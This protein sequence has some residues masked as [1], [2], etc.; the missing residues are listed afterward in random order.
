MSLLKVLSVDFRSFDETKLRGYLFLPGEGKFPAVCLCHGIPIAPREP[1]D[2]GY[3]EV[4][5]RFSRRGIAALTFN[6]RG[7]GVSE[8]EFD[9]FAWPADLEAAIDYLYNHK[10]VD[11]S[12]LGVAGFSGGALVALYVA[13]R[14]AR[15]KALALCATPADTS[16]VTVERAEEVV[17]MARKSGSLRGIDRPGAALK[18]KRDFEAL[19]PLSLIS[20]ISCPVLVL[21][22]EADELIPPSQAEEL[23]RRAKEPKRLRI[24]KGAAHKL[25]LYPEAM[26]ELVKWFYE[27]WCLS[28]PPL[29]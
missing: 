19:N 17:D 24:I 3:A 13:S 23:Y 9:L 14:D 12:R 26:E 21:H 11:T 27:L 15:V 4:A 28:P 1:G 18:L 25:R 6:F 2:R 10:S 22:G 20:S 8:G 5:E 29:K 7:V 16:R